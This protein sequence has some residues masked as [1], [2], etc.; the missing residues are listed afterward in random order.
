MIGVR[1][2]KNAAPYHAVTHDA[3]EQ[4]ENREVLKLDWNEATIEPSP[5]VL[6]A[7][8]QAVTQGRLNWY[9]DLENHDLLNELHLYTD[10]PQDHIQY[11]AS[12]DAAHE[13]IFKAFTQENDVVAV[14]APTYD[15]V[16][17][18]AE[19]MGRKVDYLFLEEGEF[20]WNYE[21]VANTLKDLSCRLVYICNPNNPT[22]TVMDVAELKRL[23]QDHPSKLFLID[24]AYF[25]FSNVTLAKAVLELKNVMISRT[26]SKAFALAS[27][28]VG[29]VLS[30]PENIQ[31]ISKIRNPK[32][33]T[34]FS[35]IAATAALQDLDYTKAYVQEVSTAREF[36]CKKLKALAPFV[37][38][39]QSGP[40]NFVLIKLAD[41]L[42]PEFIRF[43]KDRFI[44]VRDF[45]A[46]PQLSEW[47]RITIG[48]REQ[49]NALYA[50][51]D[52]FVRQQL[53]KSA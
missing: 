46:H 8:E 20:Y 51:I 41:G 11:F 45:Q 53:K 1:Y 22:G 27:F 3:W 42:K 13:Y 34:A 12:S 24:E 9:P 10:L 30:C 5:V 16:R 44:Y 14:L 29:Y 48:T 17:A 52:I 32:S 15:N 6:K 2:L 43:L 47:L 7:L 21:R 18:T 19:G 23:V 38:C 37:D 26:F 31:L 35:Q 49:M 40:T 39:V 28:R 50:V 4:K 36:F 25:E 33:V